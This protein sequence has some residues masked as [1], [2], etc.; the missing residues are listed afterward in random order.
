MIL[1][2]ASGS[3][4][5][6]E[7]AEK[8]IRSR[9]R[10]Q[11]Q[12]Q[13]V[14]WR[15]CRLY[16]GAF[17]LAQQAVVDE[18]TGELVADGT[19]QQCCDHTRIDTARK[20]EHHLFPAHRRAHLG[21]ETLDDVCRRPESIAATDGPGEVV[22]DGLALLGVG[23]LRVKLHGIDTLLR[24][25]HRR[26]R[27]RRRRRG[28]PESRRQFDHL[29]TMTHPYRQP[30]ATDPPLTACSSRLSASTSMTA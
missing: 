25:L 30:A 9:D 17:V 4:D 14:G 6:G 8:F 26:D 1:R 19:R 21:N 20:S 27:G 15:E 16:F 11:I 24:A 7:L 3:A 2:L 23:Y 13:R 5:S 10:D 29:V 28:D 12:I 18:Y 22:N